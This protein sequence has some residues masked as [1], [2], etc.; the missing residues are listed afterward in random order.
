MKRLL[1]TLALLAAVLA[2]CTPAGD[3]TLKPGQTLTS[4]GLSVT[5]IEVLE[6]SRC[7]ADAMCIWQG[8]VKVRIEVAAG[9]EVQQYV[10][11]LGELLAGDTNAAEVPG[12]TVSL[13]DV[14][15]YPLASQPASFSDYAIT[16]GI[17]AH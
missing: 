10:L 6:D 9:T 16:L 4:G 12:H 3:N 11:T 1:L 15:P 8:N 7:P 17:A 14:Q 5:F 13:Q 2:A